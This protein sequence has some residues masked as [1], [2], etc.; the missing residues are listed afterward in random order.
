VKRTDRLHAHWNAAFESTPSDRHS[1]YQSHPAVSLK[2][3]ENSGVGRSD[4]VIDVGGGASLLVDALVEREFETLTVLDISSAALGVSQRRMGQR[5]ERVE[6]VCTDVRDFHP[7]RRYRLWHD[8]ALFHFLTRETDRAQYRRA[9][10]EALGA[11]GQLILATFATDGPTRCSGMD[12]MQYDAARISA[13]LGE[14]F[15]LLEQVNEH[16][17]TP[18]GAEQRFSWFRL[19]RRC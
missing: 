7:A 16:H 13:E 4:A 12:T 3:I 8:R 19:E 1:W 14:D 6:W 17:R 11:G 15:H 9:L 18:A 5:A 2:L 10:N